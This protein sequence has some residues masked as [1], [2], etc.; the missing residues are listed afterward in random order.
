MINVNIFPFAVSRSTPETSSP[1]LLSMGDFETNFVS[2]PVRRKLFSS[3]VS[4]VDELSVC[5]I[6][7]YCALVGG[8]FVQ[9]GCMS[10]RDLDLLVFYYSSPKADFAGGVKVTQE[11]RVSG[12]DARLAPLD[13]DPVTIIKFSSFFS[14][15]YSIDRACG[16]NRRA[17][18][19]VKFP[20]L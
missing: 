16:V 13:A 3:F 11:Y 5:G 20:G 4:Y 10:P 7:S 19:L 15:L 17:S 1:Y 12:I 9:S 8:S 6:R 14:S 2:N 18:Y